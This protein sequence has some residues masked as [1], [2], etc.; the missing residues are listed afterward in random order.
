MPGKTICPSA[1][2]AV[3]IKMAKLLFMH[4]FQKVGFSSRELCI[5]FSLW[6]LN[7]YKHITF[8]VVSHIDKIK[9]TWNIKHKL[10]H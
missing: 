1:R 2:K 8:C 7:D 10:E 9:I 3:G 6:D 5:S 4:I